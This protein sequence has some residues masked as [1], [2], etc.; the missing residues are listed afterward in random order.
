MDN[1]TITEAL[2]TLAFGHDA[3]D[4]TNVVAAVRK[5]QAVV[6]EYT[7][8]RPEALH[9]LRS[10]DDV[11]SILILVTENGARDIFA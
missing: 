3:I 5:A 8:G 10:V 6:V 7:G 9:T 11:D 1:I 4:E 2:Y